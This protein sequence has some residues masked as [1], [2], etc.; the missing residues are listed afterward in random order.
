VSVSAVDL[1]RRESRSN[2]ILAKRQRDDV[3]PQV[4]KNRDVLVLRAL[5]P[6]DNPATLFNLLVPMISSNVITW[7]IHDALTPSVL[8]TSCFR[9][10]SLSQWTRSNSFC[11]LSLSVCVCVKSLASSGV[12]W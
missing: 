4:K 7:I 5:L 11:S 3:Q 2:G 12:M 1:S 8:A 6:V 9:F 10:L